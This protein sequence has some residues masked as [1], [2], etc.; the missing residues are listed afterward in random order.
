M[1]LALS[2]LKGRSASSESRLED[3]AGFDRLSPTGYSMFVNNR[4]LSPRHP[5]PTN[6]IPD[7]RVRVR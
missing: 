5:H 7:R 1:P 2:L 4:Y 3:K 6:R